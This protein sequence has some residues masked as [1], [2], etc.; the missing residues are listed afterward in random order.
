[1]PGNSLAP[2]G[3]TVQY[4]EVSLTGNSVISK[5]YI[6][7][8][9]SNTEMPY[10]GEFISWSPDSSK[11]IYG[12]RNND[13]ETTFSLMDITTGIISPITTSKY[14]RWIDNNRYLYIDSV[15]NLFFSTLD[16]K[17]LKIDVHLIEPKQVTDFYYDS[18]YI[19]GDGTWLLPFDFSVAQLTT[20]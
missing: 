20:K 4:T 8:Q 6:H 15:A 3:K 17:I 2:D 16:E 1:M 18:F 5:S 7:K 11:I 10:E 13:R 14:M 9:D 12:I 19:I